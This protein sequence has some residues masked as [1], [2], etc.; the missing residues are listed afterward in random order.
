MIGRTRMGAWGVETTAARLADIHGAL[1]CGLHG[2]AAWIAAVPELETKIAWSY[3]LY[4][5]A[6]GADAVARRIHGLTAERP[7]VPTPHNQALW[8]FFHALLDLETTEE[9]IAGLY[10]VLLSAV[11]ESC[12]EHLA[13]TNP[14]ADEPTIRVLY[15][16]SEALES[17]VI[18]S[19]K[20]KVDDATVNRLQLD[21][22]EAGGLHGGLTQTPAGKPLLPNPTTYAGEQQFRPRLVAVP[23]RDVRFIPIEPDKKFPKAKPLTTPEG[24]IRLLHIALINLEI[25]AIE[26]CGRMIAEFPESPWAM[27]LELAHQ[28]W[29]EARHAVMC[30]DRLQAL[31]GTIGQFPYHHRVWEHSL[32]GANL[33]ERFITTQRIHEGNGIDQT[34]LARDAL[35]EVGDFESS[36]VMDYILAD[37]VLHVRSGNTWLER[38][39]SGPEERAALLQ[40]VEERLG[41]SAAKGGPPLNRE[42]R[43]KA[44]FTDVELDWL[45][46]FRPQP[47]GRE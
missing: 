26:V 20:Q 25:P 4:D 11:L 2:L 42:G 10:G 13:R 14:V 47:K 32:E 44:G 38:L 9:Q 7:E 18:W 40:G 21:L 23:A 1:L 16:L 15:P 6:A 27:K 19:S 12:Q 29:D 46:S 45:A 33:A 43:Q 30:A 31:G 8:P 35:A 22:T 37:E 34:L 28:I 24:R 17:M 36:Q 41:I 3:H 39:T 5:L